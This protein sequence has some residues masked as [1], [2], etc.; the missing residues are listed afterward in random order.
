[1]DDWGGVPLNLCF[2][3]TTW[4]ILGILGGMVVIGGK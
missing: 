2:M 4:L 1:M 3:K